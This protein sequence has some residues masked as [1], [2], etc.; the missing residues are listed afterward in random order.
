MKYRV[1]TPSGVM[2]EGE[3]DNMADIPRVLP[4]RFERY[5][6]TYET[7][8]VK[9]NEDGEVIG[10]VTWEEKD[11]AGNTWWNFIAKQV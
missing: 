10:V 6:E 11:A 4:D 1:L 8:T 9:V 5:F 3:W 2:A 7:E